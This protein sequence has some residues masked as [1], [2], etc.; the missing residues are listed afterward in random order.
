MRWSIPGSRCSRSNSDSIPKPRRV[1]RRGGKRVAQGHVQDGH[2]RAALLCGAQ[3]FECLGTGHEV[4]ERCFRGTESQVGGIGFDELAEDA[5]LRHRAAFASA[6]E[7]SLPDHGRIRFRKEGEEHG[8]SPSTVIALQKAVGDGKA[9][10]KAAAEATDGYTRFREYIAK[11]EERRPL[12]PRDLLG[13]QDRHRHPAR[14]GETGRWGSCG[15]FIRPRCRSARSSPEA[16]ATVSIAMNRIGV[17]STSG[18]GG[19][20]RSTTPLPKRRPGRQPDQAGGHR[21]RS[22]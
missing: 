18:E 21:S 13:F 2:R 11:A 1:P 8:W 15:C 7:L 17:R 16:H 22:G 9:G 20:I 12:T 4:I 5:L 14:R 3:I 10:K 6:D 19:K